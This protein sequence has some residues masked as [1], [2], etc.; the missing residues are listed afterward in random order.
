LLPLVVVV[1][2]LLLPLLLS[3]LSLRLPAAPGAVRGQKIPRPYGR[4]F[5]LLGA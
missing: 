4:G 1:V 5:L 2:A 3:L